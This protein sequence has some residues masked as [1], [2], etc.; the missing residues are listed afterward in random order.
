MTR[1]IEVGFIKEFTIKNDIVHV[2][3][4]PKNYR[5]PLLQTT[6]QIDCFNVA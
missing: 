1:L 3:R 2:K 4:I 6:P 5:A